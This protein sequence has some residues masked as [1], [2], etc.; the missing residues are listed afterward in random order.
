LKI[1]VEVSKAS[2]KLLKNRRLEER[3]W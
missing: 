2:K 3:E 1:G